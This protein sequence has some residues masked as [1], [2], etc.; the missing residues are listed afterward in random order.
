MNRPAR[1]TELYMQMIDG[2]IY[3]DDPRQGFVD[4]G[5]FVHPDL[6]F[7]YPVPSGWR[8]INQP[9]RLFL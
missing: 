8:V 2:I 3:G 4:N 1:N 6:A 5:R 9:S 7:Q